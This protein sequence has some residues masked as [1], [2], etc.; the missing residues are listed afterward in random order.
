MKPVTGAKKREVKRRIALLNK[1]RMPL[2]VRNVEE[3]LTGKDAER[4][5]ELDAEV[6]RLVHLLVPKF[7]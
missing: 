3:G 1:E 2:I 4:L 6:T 7:C 5:V